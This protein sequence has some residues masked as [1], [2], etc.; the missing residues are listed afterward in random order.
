[1][2]VIRRDAENPVINKD[3]FNHPDTPD[4]WLYIGDD[5]VRYALGEPGNY[6]LVVVGLNPSKATPQKSDTT[7]SKVCEIAKLEGFDG[8]IMINL[9]PKRSI[10]PKK[11]AVSAKQE[12]TRA[13]LAII[14][15]IS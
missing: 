1:M 12:L 8:W 3:F 10:D 2:Q 14:E 5:N 7:I 13:N 11:L 4:G 15:W 9:Y 6:N